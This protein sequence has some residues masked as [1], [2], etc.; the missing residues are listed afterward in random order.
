MNTRVRELTLDDLDNLPGRCRGCVFWQTTKAGR[1]GVPSDRE[2]Q[3]AW[4]QAIQL[5][6]GVPGRAI[7]R[8]ER[9][10]GFALFAPPLHVQRQ[11]VFG[12]A[13]SEDALMLLTMWIDPDARHGGLARHLMQVVVRTAIAHD[14]DAVEAYGNVWSIEPEETGACVLGSGFLESVGFTLHRGDLEAPLYR[15]ETARTARWAD[16]VGG[17]LGAM[18][19]AL[20]RRERAPAR[21]ALES[22]TA[23]A[24]TDLAE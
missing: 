1:G 9:M 21:P 7:W 17:T 3:D 16:H 6:W 13:A 2:A 4:W 19:E 5:E 10:V 11:R 20:S 18:V 14:L 23:S 12:P 15:I 22:R 24:P 8:G